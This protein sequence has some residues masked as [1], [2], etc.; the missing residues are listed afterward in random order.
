MSHMKSFLALASLLVII[1]TFLFWSL[2]SPST[3]PKHFSTPSM[4]PEYLIHTIENI[5]SY[6]IDYPLGDDDFGEMGRR[7]EILGDWLKPSMGSYL[8][9]QE[10]QSIKHLAQKLAMSLFPFLP[11]DRSLLSAGVQSFAS[12]SRG[13]VIPT[14]LAT[15]RFACHLISCIRNVLHSNLPIQIM[16]AGEND[17]PEPYRKMLLS[18]TT[19]I[20]TLDILTIFKNDNLEFSRSGWA[21]K[22]FAILASRFQ[23]VLLADA[24]A[25]FLQPPEVIFDSHSGYHQTGT[26]LFHD[27]LLWKGAFQDRHNWWREQL[28]HRP[29][30]QTLLKS[31]V[32]T[33]DYAEEGDSGVVVVDKGRV[34]VLMG[35]LHICWQNTLTVREKWTYRLTYG[36]KESW[37]FG[38]ELSGVP[39]AFEQHYGSMLG[40]TIRATENSNE[41]CS[42]VIAHVD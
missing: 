39:Y 6:F 31:L 20:E 16:Y 41:L 1:F 11:K 10:N 18:L 34:P 38:F 12:E 35:L 13:I 14:G 9:D 33:E 19:D 22:P 32:Y 17:L 28:K 4:P 25:V 3:E 24:D 5:S 37:W 42:F 8:T 23:H 2:L 36:D 30:S 40:S 7:V 29:P 26:L 21:I 27:R 15:F